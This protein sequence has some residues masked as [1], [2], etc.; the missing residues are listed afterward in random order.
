MTVRWVRAGF[1]GPS[2]RTGGRTLEA[3][4][5]SC[6][7]AGH[8]ANAYARRCRWLIRPGE[9]AVFETYYRHFTDKL[10]DALPAL[11]P[12]VYLHYDAMTARDYGGK[13]LLPRQCMDFLMLLENHVRIVLEVD[14]K[15]Y[16]AEG[17]VA[18]PSRY[19]QMVAEDR[20]LR[21]RATSSTALEPRSLLM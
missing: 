2:L 13:P 6:P 17:D 10:G 7:R 14:G 19:A 3:T 21:L 15:H 5:T 11:I 9:A 12:Q 20:V 1:A 4:W 16:F 18:S 8:W